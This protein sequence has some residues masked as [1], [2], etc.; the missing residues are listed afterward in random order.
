VKARTTQKFDEARDIW[1]GR[2]TGAWRF[3]FSIDE[4]TYVL[5]SI[6]PHP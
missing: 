4:D 3:Y 5:H 2:V 6:T 1:Q